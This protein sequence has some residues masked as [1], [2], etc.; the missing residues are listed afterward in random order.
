MPA[1]FPGRIVQH[2]GACGRPEPG[3]RFR[4]AAGAD[5]P[6]RAHLAD[7]GARGSTNPEGERHGGTAA[8]NGELPELADPG[9]MNFPSGW[10]DTGKCRG[11][12]PAGKMKTR[13]SIT[14]TLGRRV[15]AR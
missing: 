11:F 13:E 15:S 10:R 4:N 5:L 8:R 9:G 3:H 14:L 12:Q 7:V 2:A 1:A 6:G